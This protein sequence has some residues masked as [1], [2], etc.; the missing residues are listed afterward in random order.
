MTLQQCR[1]AL[2]IVRDGSFSAAAKALY[3]SQSSLSAAVM[4][5]ER[6]LG[7]QLFERSN[8][9]VTITGDGMEF[10][11]YARQLVS[12]ADIVHERYSRQTWEARYFSI[13]SQ[14]YDF[15]AE[16]FVAFIGQQTGGRYSFSLKETRTCEVIEDVKALKSELGILKV[17]DLSGRYME[18]LFKNN[19]LAFNP[20]LEAT[21]HLFVGAHHPLSGR[22]SVTKAEFSDYPYITY[23]QGER[24][25]APFSE[26]LFEPFSN[27][28][29]LRIDDR[30][31]LMNLLLDTDSCTVGTG[32]MTSKLNNGSIA[33]IPIEDAQTCKIGYLVRE[34]LELTDTAKQ[35]IQI[36]KDTVHATVCEA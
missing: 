2:Q 26:E 17:D 24:D 33:A 13:S 14:H 8:R 7:I 27:R 31:T 20:L 4:D 9:G 34:D 22:A 32:I 15:V 5:L 29:N 18:H 21:S 6:E 19:G 23:E 35:F 3:I 25:A 10:I 36:L 30:A 12:Q 11:G 16:A 1:Y 28:R